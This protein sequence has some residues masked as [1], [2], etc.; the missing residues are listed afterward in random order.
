[1]PA[2]SGS[3]RRSARHQPGPGL[4]GPGGGGP[5]GQSGAP[6]GQSGG[7]GG[8]SGGNGRPR[9]SGRPGGGQSR[10]GGGQR[11][12]ADP[13][14]RTAYD[15]LIAVDRAGCLCQ[16]AAPVAADGEGGDRA[17]RG[18]GHRADLRRAAR[19]G[20]VI[21]RHP[22]HLDGPGPR[23]CSTRPLR[24]VLWGSA[25][26][27]PLATRTVAHAAV[28]TG[29]DLAGNTWRAR[30]R[31]GFVNAVLRLFRP[32][33]DLGSW[34]GDRRP[35]PAPTTG[36]GT[37][38][39]SYSHPALDRRLRSARS[40]GQ[41]PGCGGL[42]RDRGGARRETSA[43]AGHPCAVPG[44][45]RP[46]RAG[47]RRR[48]S[49]P[50]GPRSA[51]TSPRGRPGPGG[52]GRPGPGVGPGRGQPA[53]GARAGL[54]GRGGRAARAWPG[55]QG[56]AGSQGPAGQPGLAGSQGLAQPGAGLW[57]VARP[58]R[59]GPGGKARLLAGLAAG[60]GARLLAADLRPHL[61]PGCSGPS[62]PLAGGCA[63]RDRGRGGRGR[64]RS[65]VACP[66]PLTGCSPTSPAPGL[67]ALRR[68]PEARWCCS[69]EDVARAGPAAARSC[70]A[71]ALDSAAPGAVV[72]YVTCSP[73]LAETLDVVT[74]VLAG[75]DDVEVL[76]APASRPARGARAA[77]PAVSGRLY[78]CAVLGRTGMA[79]TRSSWP[80]CAVV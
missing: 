53:G 13:A 6:G 5:G 4:R 69:P 34:L 41:D 65:G 54:G 72:A 12:R 71:A 8:Q 35:E 42:A 57:L 74:D 55:S 76:D 38:S 70:W 67:G 80:C 52:P 7:P 40:P 18:A 73:H 59:A 39:V 11:R 17:R 49:R 44:S 46:C 1:M 24:L 79:P 30:A 75:R 68:L 31:P 60:R 50:G 48:R 29:V 10:P 51:L 14:R 19:P 9:G 63:C 78:L 26:N 20:A 16:P 77:L 66:G 23:S 58:L 56:L 25:R 32:T 36:S 62:C 3:P 43:A 37:W 27:E 22:R 28:A 15:V 64:D 2:A 47:G 21:R 45:R 33:R 61:G